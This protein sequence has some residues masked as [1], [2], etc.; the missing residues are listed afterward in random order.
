MTGSN[1]WD[2][3][4]ARVETKVNRHSFYTWFK[5][6]GFVS[7]R[8]GSIRVRVPNA[9]FRDWL[10]KHY[11]A[12]IDE[13]LTEV[14]RPGAPVHFVTDDLSPPSPEPAPPAPEPELDEASSPD[15]L[16]IMS[17]RYSFDTFIVG[18]SNQFAHAA[19]RAVA[20]APSRSYNPL[21]IYGGVGLGK[22]H[23]MHAIGHY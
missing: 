23:L 9:L 12:V 8:D 1:I 6:T 7:D 15:E 10:T 5:P 16:G 3:V 19:C 21:F 17:P 11:A 20:E 4:L 22:T 14:Q 18:P 2:Q 13:A